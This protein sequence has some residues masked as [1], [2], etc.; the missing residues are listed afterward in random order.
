VTTDL[1]GWRPFGLHT[2][3]SVS[4]LLQIPP[5]GARLRCSL[6]DRSGQELSS[7]N[8]LLRPNGAAFFDSRQM[9]PVPDAVTL[10]IDTSDLDAHRWRNSFFG[11]IDWYDTDTSLA[12]L[13]SDHTVSNCRDQVIPEIFQRDG[14]DDYEASGRRG[15]FEVA[16]E[17]A[18][19][20]IANA[21]ECGVLTEDQNREIAQL[22]AKA[23][24]HIVEVYSGT[25]EMI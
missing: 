4:G 20:S 25:V 16:R 11:L 2:L 22:A 6:L 17:K 7:W 15:A 1:F 10:R 12:S 23:D 18:L 21:P 8:A 13:H 24:Q 5:G 19:A 9:E 3:V 14:R